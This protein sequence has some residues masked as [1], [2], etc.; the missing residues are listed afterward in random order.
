VGSTDSRRLC[1]LLDAAATRY[2]VEAVSVAEVARVNE[3]DD[4]V[5]GHLPLKDL[6]A[7]LGGA[8]EVRPG[9]AVVL[10]TSPTLALRVA[11]V[12]GVLDVSAH[13]P[14]P[15][16][17]R[18][19]PLLSPA[20]RSGVEW[21]GRLFFE[22]DPDS[23]GRGL[24]KQTRRPEVVA[25]EAPP[26]SLVFET[27][28]LTLGVPLQAVRQVVAKGPG[29]NPAPSA[30]AFLGAL[31]HER[32]LLPAWSL[33]GDLAE[34]FFVIVE[35]GPGDAL[36]LSAKRADGVRPPDRLEEVTVVDLP[37]TFS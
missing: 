19:V 21:D 1:A 11:H 31:L 35:V 33:S 2:C 6:S 14:L 20:V 30:G 13:A 10:D 29:F 23:V 24:P 37:R 26:A 25:L 32:A 5:R 18:M 36:A 22:I 28:E 27:G 17:R 8:A 34:P 4:T 9:E 15:L 7:L 12:E 3:G 16:S